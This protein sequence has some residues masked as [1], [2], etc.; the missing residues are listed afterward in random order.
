MAVKAP[1]VKT[2]Q[3]SPCKSPE[4]W[5]GSALHFSEWVY[6]C[7]QN[8]LSRIKCFIEDT[9]INEKTAWNKVKIQTRS[10]FK[11][12]KQ[13]CSL[14]SSPLSQ[15]IMNSSTFLSRFPCNCLRA[16]YS[17]SAVSVWSTVKRIF[18]AIRL[19]LPGNVLKCTARHTYR[20]PALKI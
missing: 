20:F 1:W 9:D 5:L 13:K 16:V 2:S 3:C 7:H 8:T 6:F 10:L 4:K 15:E 18:S 14:F 11:T 17:H 12:N 19:A